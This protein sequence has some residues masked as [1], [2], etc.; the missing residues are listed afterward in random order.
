[1]ASARPTVTTRVPV[2]RLLRIIAAL[3]RRIRVLEDRS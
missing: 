2:Q 1:M 3:E